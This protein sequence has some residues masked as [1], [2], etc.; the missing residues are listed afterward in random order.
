SRLAWY[1]CIACKG[2]IEESHKPKMLEGGH[3][4]SES[5]EI[6]RDGRIS[7]E[8][9]ISKRVG[10]HLNSLYSPWRTFA[11]MAAEW[12]RAEGDV[13]ATMNFRNSR[14]A[15]PFEVQVSRREPSKIREKA[16]MAAQLG[17]EGAE[18]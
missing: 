10:F 2:R 12:I 18:R 11:E 14:L 13:A 16:E 7:G 9:P 6:D 15:E 4:L 5:Q 1:E 17:H 8:R 3:W